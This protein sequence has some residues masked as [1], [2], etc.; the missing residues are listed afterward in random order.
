MVRI[1]FAV[2]AVVLASGLAGCVTTGVI[3]LTE[4]AYVDRVEVTVEKPV[5]TVNL[6]EDIR[7][8]TLTEASRYRTTGKP[9]TL[10]V[11]VRDM[12]LKDP[13]LS[14]LIGDANRM[15]ARVAVVDNAT[16]ATQ[17]EF[18]VIVRDQAHFN[19]V[20]GAAIS[21]MQNPVD[22]ER[23][24]A[25]KFAGQALLQLYG[26]DAALQASSAPTRVVTAKYAKSYDELRNARSAA[27]VLHDQSLRERP[28]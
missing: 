16:K 18:D 11:A 24:L 3:A 5:G 19:G 7:V 27:D 13:A 17:A 8:K 9:L 21:V 10:R 25:D 14:I 28:L 22:V 1:C 20:V 26:N 4:H 12:T 15:V 2:T 23:D 6:A